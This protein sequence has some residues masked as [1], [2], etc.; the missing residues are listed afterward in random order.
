MVDAG[1]AF[2]PRQEYSHALGVT[3]LVFGF[4]GL[5]RVAG[6]ASPVRSSATAGSARASGS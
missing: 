4:P 5:R 6:V 3:T 2:N 1:D